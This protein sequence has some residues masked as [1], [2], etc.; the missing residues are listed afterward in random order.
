MFIDSNIYAFLFVR[1][2]LSKNTEVVQSRSALFPKT[3]THC[4]IRMSAID[5]KRTVVSVH[6]REFIR[7]GRLLMMGQGRATS[8]SSSPANLIRREASRCRQVAGR[9]GASSQPQQNEAMEH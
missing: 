7:F 2:P 5:P 3:D 9:G 1:C 6:A 4:I 8:R